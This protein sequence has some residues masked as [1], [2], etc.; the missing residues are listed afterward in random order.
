MKF[1]HIADVHWGARPEREQT[2][3]RIREQEIKETFQR[4]ID[5]ANKQ[6]VDLLLI[7][8]DLFDQPPTQQELREVDYLLSRLNHTRTVLIAG[9]HDHLEPH[10][11]FSQ[12][13]WNSEVYLLDGK[14]RDHISFEDLKTTIYGFSYWKNQITKPLYDHMKP[15]ESEG[16][17]FSILLAHGGD[18]SHIPIQREALKW[19]GFDYIALGHIHKPEIIFEDLMAYAG[20]L[21]PL[22]HTEMGYHGLIEGEISEEKKQITFVP[23]A[24][25]MYTQVE[26]MISDEMSALEIVDRVET[27]LSYRG[28]ENIYEIVLTGSIDSQIHLDFYEI[29][30]QYMVTDIIY[31]TKNQWEYEQLSEEDDFIIQKVAD[32][33]KDEPEALRYAMEALTYARE[34]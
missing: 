2:F 32:I 20:S 9:N 15:D 5:H 6:Q 10:D 18:A 4:V 25:R 16:S 31:E 1:I 30:S 34:K 23:F 12:Y 3:G 19:S 7:A 26:V 13:K 22:D 29:T 28:R 21:E 27:E 14:Q 17:D 24:K 33:L 11:V 8:G